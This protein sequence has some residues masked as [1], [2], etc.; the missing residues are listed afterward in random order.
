[1]IYN[2]LNV[3]VKHTGFFWHAKN[4]SNWHKKS[5]Q[6]NKTI[7]TSNQNGCEYKSL[8]GLLQLDFN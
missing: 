4:K 1:M 7:I 8:N 6:Q 3:S 5:F 2:S